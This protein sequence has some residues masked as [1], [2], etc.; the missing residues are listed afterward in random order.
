VP[1]SSWDEVA[2]SDAL[3]AARACRPST[4]SCSST[5]TLSSAALLLASCG[6]PLVANSLL[7]LPICEPICAKEMVGTGSGLL[8]LSASSLPAAMSAWTW[9]RLCSPA[10]PS[11]ELLTSAN[12]PA[13]ACGDL[14]FPHYMALY[15]KLKLPFYYAVSTFYDRKSKYIL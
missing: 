11:P 12:A 8:N 5:S 15:D 3:A 13:D 1:R 9:R 2:A 14:D 4:C 10:S 7:A 6:N